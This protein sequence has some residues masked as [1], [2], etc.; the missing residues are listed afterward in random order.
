MAMYVQHVGNVL[1]LQYGIELPS[2]SLLNQ[3]VNFFEG[4]NANYAKYEGVAAD[5]FSYINVIT[6]VVIKF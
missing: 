1:A 5:K 6:P 2:V 3:K 4:R